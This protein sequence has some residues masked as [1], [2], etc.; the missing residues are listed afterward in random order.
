M[1]TLIHLEM[2]RILLAV[3]AFFTVADNG[4]QISLQAKTS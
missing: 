2:M 4:E 1:I 3:T